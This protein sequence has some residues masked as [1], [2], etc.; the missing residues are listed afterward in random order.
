MKSETSAR[1]TFWVN[2]SIA[3]LVCGLVFL[4]PT[5][6]RWY[7][8]VRPLGR[9]G[10]TA[11]FLGFYA[12]VPVI[13]YALWCIDRLLKNILGGRVFVMDNVRKIRRL[14]WCCAGVSLICVPAAFFY[15]PLIFLAVI[16]A[17]L[18]LVI[19]VVKNVMAAAVELREESDL[20]I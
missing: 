20:T 3:V 16:M 14:R 7:V 17:F 1:I 12:C 9:Q 5:V 10:A 6:L 11:I 19:S 4:M 13:L 18:A 8:Q 15:L 2:R